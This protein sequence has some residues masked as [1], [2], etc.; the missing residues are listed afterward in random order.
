MQVRYLVGL[1]A[2]DRLGD[3]SLGNQDCLCGESVR[4]QLVRTY[5]AGSDYEHA[6][7]FMLRELTELVSCAVL[8]PPGDAAAVQA[9]RHLS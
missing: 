4:Q 3:L 2:A 1:P 7:H 8:C 5:M 9:F 6:G